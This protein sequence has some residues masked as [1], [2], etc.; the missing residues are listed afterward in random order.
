MKI[1]LLQPN[2]LKLKLKLGEDNSHLTWSV[3]QSTQ[4]NWEITIW[5]LVICIKTPELSTLYN[6]TWLTKQV[7]TIVWSSGKTPDAWPHPG[8]QAGKVGWIERRRTNTLPEK[9][10]TQKAEDCRVYVYCYNFAPITI[11]MRR[12]KLQRKINIGRKIQKTLY[13]FMS[14]FSCFHVV[15]QL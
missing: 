9:L 3:V 6:H 1:L 5:W 11:R 12:I 14:L 13:A 4:S 7:L 10:F 8:G 2:K 15:S